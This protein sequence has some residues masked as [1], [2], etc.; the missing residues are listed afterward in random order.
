MVVGLGLMT[1]P[2][3]MQ[4][5]DLKA[6]ASSVPQ[7]RLPGGKVVGQEPSP[8]EAVAN[9]AQ[10][11]FQGTTLPDADPPGRVRGAVMAPVQHEVSF[12]CRAV[13][14]ATLGHYRGAECQAGIMPEHRHFPMPG[15]DDGAWTKTPD[16]KRMAVA[17]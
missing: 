14:L 11:F 10:A 6:F 13:S 9:V 8:I 4:K 1:A 5:V 17:P 3:W 15:G 7:A 2:F 12:A 16:A